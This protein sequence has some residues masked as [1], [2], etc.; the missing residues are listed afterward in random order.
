MPTETTLIAESR[1]VAPGGTV[2]VPIRL[3]R[4]RD[5]GSIGFEL[6]YE[7]GVAQ[8]IR[9]LKDSLMEPA[10]FTYNDKVPGVI[11]FGFAT[12]QGIGGDGSAAVVEFKAVGAEGSKSPLTLSK[13]EATDTSGA[14][15]S[16]R[17]V[18]GELTIIEELIL[19]DCNR[20]RKITVVDA[21]CALQ[22]YVGLRDVDMVMDVDNDGR[23]TAEDARRIM[24]MAKR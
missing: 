7:P 22:M 8:V 4:A 1:E 19:G 14:P 3:E 13:G 23:V 5:I 20:D 6:S 18:N 21:L 15:L 10:T 9:V 16:F 12:T 2:Q 17:L 11:R 24:M